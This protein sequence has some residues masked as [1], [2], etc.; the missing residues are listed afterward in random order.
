MTRRYGVDFKRAFP[1][2]EA[3]IYAD[4]VRCSGKSCKGALVAMNDGQARMSERLGRMVLKCDGC[5]TQWSVPVD[6]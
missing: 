5:L 2:T 6:V 3:A 1:K 4:S